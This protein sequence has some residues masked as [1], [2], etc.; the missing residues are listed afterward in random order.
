VGRIAADLDLASAPSIALNGA[1]VVEDGALHRPKLVPRASAARFLEAAGD[2]ETFLYS[3]W[4][5]LVLARG[6]AADREAEAVGF[7]PTVVAGLD[8]APTLEKINAVGPAGAVDALERRLEGTEGRLVRPTPE[9][10]ELMAPG[11][12]K[13]AALAEL[14]VRFEGLVAVGD[15]D[16]DADMLERAGLGVAMAGARPR[17]RAAADRVVGHHDSDT[18]ADLLDELRAEADA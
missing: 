14:G 18:L 3:G 4:A 9:S 13:G 6:P 16:N 2:L 17:A 8:E 15:G 11:V 7:A 10:L 12:S 1:V 5:W